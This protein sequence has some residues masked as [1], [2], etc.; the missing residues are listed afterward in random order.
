[1]VTIYARQGCGCCIAEMKFE[2]IESAD[3]AFEEAGL[4]SAAVIIDDGG[5]E[6]RIDTFYHFSQSFDEQNERGLGFLLV[7]AFGDSK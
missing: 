4:Q 5:T 7:Q 2:S 3:K 6:W 1:M